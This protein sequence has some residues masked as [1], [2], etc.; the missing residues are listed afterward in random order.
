MPV[1]GGHAGVTILPVF[2]QATPKAALA[3]GEDEALTK[4]VQDAGTVVV[5]KKEGK[6]SATL[7]MARAAEVCANA[8]LKGLSGAEAVECAYVL[9]DL[10]PGVPYFATRVQFGKG[11]VEKVMPL[12]DLNAFERA[13]LETMVPQ[14]KS[15]ID[16]G[17]AFA[18][19]YKTKVAA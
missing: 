17:V 15:E 11:G 7:S 5:E 14:L 9:T 18:A 4:K 3:A 16:K 12:G 13:A 10:V 19:G 6:G 2:S 1:I 8:I